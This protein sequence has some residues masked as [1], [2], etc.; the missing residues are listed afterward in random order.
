MPCLYII[1]YLELCAVGHMPLLGLFAGWGFLSS[2]MF[3]LINLCSHCQLLNYLCLLAYSLC[4]FSVYSC[5]L[6]VCWN[7]VS[8][9]LRFR[10]GM[11][12]ICLMYSHLRSPQPVPLGPSCFL[13][14]AV[15]SENAVN[16]R[17]CSMSF[18]NGIWKFLLTCIW[19]E[20]IILFPLKFR[21]EK[22]T[23]YICFSI[24]VTCF[25]LIVS[26]L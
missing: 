25:N 5:L 24:Q 22:F 6:P 18:M 15:D 1:P 26:D 19:C 3:H 8:R 14:G 11:N 20:H 23:V 17:Y 9:N 10:K 2:L 16:S 21:R 13:F 4:V 12:R 7:S